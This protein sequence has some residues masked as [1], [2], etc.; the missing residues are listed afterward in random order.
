MKKTIPDNKTV[1]DI[2]VQHPVA[3]A[4]FERHGVDYCCGGKQDLKTAARNAGLTVEQLTDALTEAIEASDNSER[5]VRDWT[6]VPWFMPIRN[7][8]AK[9]LRH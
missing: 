4:V 6:A 7:S 1:A 5:D 2:V 9:C 8:T 3:L